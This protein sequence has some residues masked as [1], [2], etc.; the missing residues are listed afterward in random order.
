MITKT[1]YTAYFKVPDRMAWKNR[2]SRAETS[3]LSVAILALAANW[4]SSLAPGGSHIEVSDVIAMTH[5]DPQI[6]LYNFANNNECRQAKGKED[7][8]D[9]LKMGVWFLP[10]GGAHV[11]AIV[12]TP[13]THFDLLV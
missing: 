3:S 11:G 12:P 6:E 5:F 10:S 2:V 1:V 8:P 13:I 9:L 7:I 4:I